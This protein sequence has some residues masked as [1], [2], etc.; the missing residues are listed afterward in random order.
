MKQ[1]LGR[2]KNK[3]ISRK[4]YLAIREAMIDYY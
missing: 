3:K 1:T 4:R 2:V